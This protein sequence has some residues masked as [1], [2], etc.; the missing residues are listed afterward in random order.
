MHNVFQIQT[1]LDIRTYSNV[2]DYYVIFGYF[3]SWLL[4]I[5]PTTDTR[6]DTETIFLKIST[7]ISEHSKINMASGHSPLDLILYIIRLPVYICIIHLLESS[8]VVKPTISNMSSISPFSD[9]L[10]IMQ[11]SCHFHF[12]TNQVRTKQCDN[13]FLQY[14]SKFNATV[15]IGF[16][17]KGIFHNM[18]NITDR[19][20]QSKTWNFSIL[21]IPS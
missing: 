14:L 2:D 12:P 21:L 13:I 16:A 9:I 20:W 11:I 5:F 7:E 8:P 4:V 3:F 1:M 6:G 15:T 18:V 10:L 19:M 17:Q